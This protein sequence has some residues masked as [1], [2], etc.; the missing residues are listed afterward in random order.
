MTKITLFELHPAGSELFQ[1]SENFLTD[2]SD[3][4]SISINGGEGY[5][6][7]QLLEYGIKG[8]EF[9]VVGFGINNVVSLAKSFSEGV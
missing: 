2:L 8:F 5:G 3:M 9:S 4:D 7:E 1:D 6:Y